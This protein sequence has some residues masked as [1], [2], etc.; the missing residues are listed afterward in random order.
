[1]TTIARAFLAFLAVPL[2]TGHAEVS[3][4]ALARVADPAARAALEEVQ[5]G[6]QG[7]TGTVARQARELEA[8]RAHSAALEARL[9]DAEG[10]LLRHEEAAAATQLRRAQEAPPPAPTNASTT[11]KMYHRKFHRRPTVP[12]AGPG[13]QNGECPAQ[14]DCTPTPWPDCDPTPRCGDGDGAAT[15]QPHEHRRA[16]DVCEAS[17]LVSGVTEI[18]R[19]CCDEPT[20]DCSSGEPKSCNPGCAA[21]VLSFWTDCQAPFSRTNTPEAV[22]TFQRVVRKCQHA[23]SPEQKRSL[24]ERFNL[25][26]SAGE[27]TGECDVPACTEHTHGYQLLATIDGEDSTLI[28]QLHHGLYSWLGPAAE[29]S[30]IGQ[31]ARTLVMAVISGAGGPFQLWLEENDAGIDVDLTVQPSQRVAISGDPAVANDG[32]PAAPRWGE[33]SFRVAQGAELRLTNLLLAAAASIA[34]S[35]GGSLALADLA[36]RT[37][38]LAFASGRGGGLSL[39]NVSFAGSAPPV[40]G[41][42]CAAGG[43]TIA[44]GVGAAAAGEID[45]WF[46]GS[47]Y[48]FGVSCGWAI[49]GCPAAEVTFTAFETYDS[50]THVDVGG[51]TLYGTDIVGTAA[52][53]QIAAAPAGGWT[54]ALNFTSDAYYG[55][56]GHYRGFRARY[57]CA[58]SAAALRAPPPPPPPPTSARRP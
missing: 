23:E 22:A 36:L 1:M 54:V 17:D 12:C 11:V 39:A 49:S 19:T 7:L 9:G 38:Q 30:Y 41:D 13:E 31:D 2:A 45:F 47:G 5:R 57:R 44:G 37:T 16:Q 29:G 14:C 21:V 3:A 52:A 25:V 43:A 34:V 18:S 20:E 51:A 4:P 33:G 27:D 40:R 50:D 32:G 24:A 10:K 35:A 6:L 8:Q 28:C 56:L 48:P 26:C 42:P 55:S 53:T 15:S 58:L 46:E